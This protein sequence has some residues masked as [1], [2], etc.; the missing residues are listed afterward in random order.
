MP[1]WEL[2]DEQDSAWKE[3]VL[4]HGIRARVAI[5]AGATFGWERYTGDHGHVIGLD[6]FGASAPAGT[7]YRELGLHVDHIVQRAHESLSKQKT[8]SH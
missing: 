1:S 7:I 5:E 2:F 6:R 4:P 3:S 8:N